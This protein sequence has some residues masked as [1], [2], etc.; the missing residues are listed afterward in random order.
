M[1]ILP[2]FAAPTAGNMHVECKRSVS[3][4]WQF[5][6]DTNHPRTV[7][8]GTD[9]H[10]MTSPRVEEADNLLNSGN[11]AEHD[12]RDTYMIRRLCDEW[13]EKL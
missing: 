12:A 7:R 9:W 11:Q 1:A 10:G 4:F 2:L 5:S 6:R 8:N 13:R 3:G